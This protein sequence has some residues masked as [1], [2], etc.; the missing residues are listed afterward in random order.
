MFC[1]LSLSSEVCKT[2][3]CQERWLLYSTEPDREQGSG[4]VPV[5][6]EGW[7]PPP[8]ENSV[9]SASSL[10]TFFRLF[11]LTVSASRSY[12]DEESAAQE[13]GRVEAVPTWSLHGPSG[14]SPRS[15]WQM[16]GPLL[17][18]YNAGH[19]TLSY[20]AYYLSCLIFKITLCTSICDEGV[21]LIPETVCF[22]SSW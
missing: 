11:S 14:R 18:G 12:P 5:L 20:C 8:T 9:L 3:C 7:T 19:S 22:P 13:G 2:W 6:S 15:F 17:L 10:W 1:E 16:V 21:L 4:H